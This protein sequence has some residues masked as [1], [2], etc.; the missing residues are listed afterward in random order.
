MRMERHPHSVGVESFKLQV[1]GKLYYPKR[2]HD[3]LAD[4]AVALRETKEN[5]LPEY[6]LNLAFTA[7][8]A[9]W[10]IVLG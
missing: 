3:S 4:E 8:I 10:H 2:Q 5:P 7:A 1:Y 6:S 9:S